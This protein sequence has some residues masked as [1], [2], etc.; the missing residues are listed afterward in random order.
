MER[1]RKHERLSAK[2]N[3]GLCL[4]DQTTGTKLTREVSCRLSDISRQGAGLKIPQI[5]ID[6]KH[7]CYTAQDSDTVDL[8]LVFHDITDESASTVILA[9]PVWFDRDMEDT[10][11]P[12]KIGV[13]FLAQASNELLKD[14]SNQ[15]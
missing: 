7:L 15:I 12:F 11:L 9:K 6:G 8:I 4:Y 2:L 14:I 10:V 1:E 3:V 13:E 5:L